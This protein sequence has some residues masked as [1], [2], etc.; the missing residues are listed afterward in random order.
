MNS[1]EWERKRSVAFFPLEAEKKRCQLHYK[2][3]G[4]FIFAHDEREKIV[5]NGFD[6]AEVDLG[7]LNTAWAGCVA[8]LVCV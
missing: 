6:V 2:A 4:H 1:S 3:P 7:A 5:M 8:T